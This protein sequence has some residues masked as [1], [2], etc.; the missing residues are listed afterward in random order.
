MRKTLKEQAIERKIMADDLDEAL[1]FLG[2]T[3]AMAYLKTLRYL[4]VKPSGMRK[5][6]WAKAKGKIRLL[7]RDY[8][9]VQGLDNA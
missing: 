5:S 6:D 8:L 1:Y 7:A 4:E 2:S 3:Q 9:R